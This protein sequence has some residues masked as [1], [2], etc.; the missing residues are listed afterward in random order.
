MLL[1]PGWARVFPR[2][3]QSC[4]GAQALQ[5]QQ[6][7]KRAQTHLPEVVSFTCIAP[8]TPQGA[9][10]CRRQDLNLRLPPRAKVALSIELRLHIAAFR[11]DSA[12]LLT[13][14]GM[15]RT[16]CLTRV[17]HV[18]G[19]YHQESNLAPFTPALG[20]RSGIEPDLWWYRQGSNL[21]RP[22]AAVSAV[23]SAN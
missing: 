16:V 9:L 4:D 2:C 1:A 11:A 10:W 3:R 22:S 18:D 15:P 23:R 17:S 19:T 7:F 20:Q 12:A 21:R 5:R 14:C 8:P 6:D 13:G